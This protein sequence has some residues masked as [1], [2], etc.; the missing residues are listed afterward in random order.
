MLMGIWGRKIG[1]TQVFSQKNT[2]VPVTVIDFSNWFV[3]Q[4]KTQDKDKYSAIQIGL[5]R[6]RFE[7]K[8]FDSVWLQDAKVYFQIIKEIQLK[9][10]PEMPF[11]V[12]QQLDAEAILQVGEQVNVFGTTKGRGFQGVVKRHNFSGGRASHG[13]RFGR[14]PGSLSF[15]RSQGRVIKGKKMP[16]HMGVDSRVMRN[17]E[18]IK[19]ENAS[20]VALVKGSVPGGS[21]ALV[22]MQKA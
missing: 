8:P 3:M 21:G 14:W 11:E 18:I 5:V 19:V 1:M 20:K 7:G 13:P 10:D 17:L 6:K 22:F 9:A 15:M 12:G 16:G 4:I 2:V